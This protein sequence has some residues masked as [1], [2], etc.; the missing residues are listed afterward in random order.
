[1]N[2]HQLGPQNSRKLGYADISLLLSIVVMVGLPGIARLMGDGGFSLLTI[3]WTVI[4]PVFSFLVGWMGGKSLRDN[5]YM[6]LFPACFYL[7]GMWLFHSIKDM[8]VLLNSGSYFIIGEVGLVL[9]MLFE[10]YI[11]KS[12]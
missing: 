4:F 7:A 1:M 10:K 9:R 5:A 8:D 11:R 6:P 12:I 2:N 3:C